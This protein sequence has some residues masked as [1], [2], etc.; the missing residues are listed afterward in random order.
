MSALRKDHSYTYKYKH[1][2][3][4]LYFSSVTLN[5]MKVQKD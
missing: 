3:I 4:I 2:R 5:A 1:I